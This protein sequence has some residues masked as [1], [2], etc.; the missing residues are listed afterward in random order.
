MSVAAKAAV[1][2]PSNM[3]TKFILFRVETVFLVRRPVGQRAYR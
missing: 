3:K 1:A 2:E